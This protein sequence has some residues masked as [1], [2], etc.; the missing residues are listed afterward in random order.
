[1]PVP[2]AA[3]E[4]HGDAHHCVHKGRRQCHRRAVHMSNDLPQDNYTAGL[5]EGFTELGGDNFTTAKL[6]QV[7]HRTALLLS[8]TLTHL[9]KVL[10]GKEVLMLTDAEQDGKAAA[11]A[12]GKTYNTTSSN[13]TSAAIYSR[14]ALEELEA[15]DSDPDFWKDDD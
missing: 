3:I 14:A 12:K 2:R 13:P 9:C 4:R 15:E 7:R 11:P 5:I 8:P 1:M 10:A 6:A